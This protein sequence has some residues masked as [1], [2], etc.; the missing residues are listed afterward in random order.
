MFS[1]EQINDTLLKRF[2][3][4]VSA[5]DYLFRQNEKGN[6]LFIIL[7]GRIQL[8]HRI[9]ATERLVGVLGAG[10]VVGEK[11][12]LGDGPHRRA[13]SALATTESSVLEFA[14]DDV[15]AL[16]ARW[17]DFTQKLLALVIRRLDKANFLVSVLQMSDPTDRVVEYLIYLHHYFGIKDKKGV[18]IVASAA[19]VSAGAN[20]ELP[21]VTKCLSHLVKK[22][23]LQ[24][25]SDGYLI[26]DD[27][28][29][30]E[31]LPVL[32]ERAAA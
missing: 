14:V 13:F 23:I 31:Y 27:Q 10:E 3:V 21:L 16:Q 17:P 1:R 4:E 29:L 26:S 8:S 15:K 25:L 18:R 12:I 11:A 5:G 30:I 7:E 20:A 19:E 2:L 28:A 24:K 6:T 22:D 9:H 32:K